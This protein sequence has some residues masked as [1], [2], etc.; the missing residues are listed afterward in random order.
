MEATAGAPGAGCGAPVITQTAIAGTLGNSTTTTESVQNSQ[1][2]PCHTDSRTA[3]PCSGLCGLYATINVEI[4]QIAELSTI[5][6]V[7]LR[8]SLGSLRMP[9]SV[10]FGVASAL[11]LSLIL[12]LWPETFPA[13]ITAREALIAALG[14]P[15]LWL[16]FDTARTVIFAWRRWSSRPYH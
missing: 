8:R 2:L 12:T 4:S 6:S 11:V 9:L 14:L 16:V 10:W 3:L 15:P 1:A 7:V 13:P 5:N